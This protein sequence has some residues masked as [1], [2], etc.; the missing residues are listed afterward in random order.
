MIHD[1][2]VRL[3]ANMATELK[4]EYVKADGAWAGSPFAWIKAQPSPS[5]R[6]K[7]GERLVAQWCRQ[8]GFR[9]G[10]VSDKEADMTVHGHRV[11][12]KFSTLWTDD[13]TYT[14][15]QIRDQDYAFLIC[16][17]VSPRNAH[18]WIIPK[19]VLCNHVIG[20][21]PQHTGK[22][23][24]DTFWIPQLNPEEPREWLE[25][26]GGTLARAAKVLR[27]LMRDSSSAPTALPA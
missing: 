1:P 24:T 2:D 7:I 19:K 10:S 26:Y 27:R 22:H 13:P 21:T 17:G 3:L 9:V 15:Q 14:F 11:E 20:H 18:C 6:G 12:V 16:L 8:H 23:G 4:R 25:P 5:R